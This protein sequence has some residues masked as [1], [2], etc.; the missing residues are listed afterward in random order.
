MG[1]VVISKAHESGFHMTTVEHCFAQKRTRIN[2][3]LNSPYT[4]TQV[5]T[6]D[7]SKETLTEKCMLT[8]QGA[9]KRTLSKNGKE[10][11][12]IGQRVLPNVHMTDRVNENPHIWRRY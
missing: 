12:K 10:F 6:R 9:L 1:K 7:G 8:H 3:D 5:T 4:H 2:L 11:M